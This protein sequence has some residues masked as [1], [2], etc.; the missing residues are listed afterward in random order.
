MSQLRRRDRRT[1]LRRLRP[2]R[3]AALK[4]GFLTKRYVEGQRAAFLPPVRLYLTVSVIY[5]LVAAAV[6]ESSIPRDGRPASSGDIKI[7]LS[8]PATD[9]LTPEQREQFLAQTRDAAWVVRVVAAAAL[10]DPEAFRA[11]LLTTMSRVFFA[12]LPVFAGIVALFYRGWRF[13]VSLVFATHLHAFG[14]AVLT[15][16]ELANVAR[17]RRSKQSST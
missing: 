5:F 6:P 7:D 8:R 11:R 16:S 4:P 17:S 12:M 9:Q 2:A 1:I 10:N 15:L 13:P 14:F 3:R